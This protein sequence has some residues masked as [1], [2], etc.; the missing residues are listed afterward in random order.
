YAA[1]LAWACW[2]YRTAHLMHIQLQALYF[3]PLALWGLHRVIARR[4]WRDVLAL[5]ALTALQITAS[6]YNGV[7]TVVALVVGG[8]VLASATGALRSV[9]LWSRLAVA[10]LVAVVLSM[11]VIV[12]YLRSQQADGFGR[13]L[14][15]ASQ[16]SASLQAY[17]QVPP[18]NLVYGRTGLLDPRPPAAGERDR[19]HVEHHL[20][21]GFVLMGLA[22][23]GAWRH[24]RSDARPLVVEG[25][26][27]VVA[28]LV[29]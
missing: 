3:M 23:V 21:P 4:R 13:T 18:V 16:H 20:F 6:V 24:W 7:M 12:P 1:G 26:A 2:P 5:A 9:R 28:G 11:P 10:G 14:Y 29:L 19:T 22:L 15:E 25:L 17:T 27:L 8:V